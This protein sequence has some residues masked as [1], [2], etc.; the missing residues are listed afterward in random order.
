[1]ISRNLIIK[2]ALEEGFDLVGVVA[3][4][5]MAEERKRFSE[6]L[7]SGAHSTLSYLE[8]NV[9]KRFDAR[10]LVDGCRSIIVCAVS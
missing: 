6:W 1:M 10:L 2:V 9:E 4:E 5:A 8:R 3:A 7:L